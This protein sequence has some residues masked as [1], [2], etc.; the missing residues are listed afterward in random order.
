M[1]L[2]LAPVVDLGLLGALDAQGT[3]GHIVAYTGPVDL[4]KSGRGWFTGICCDPNYGGRGIASI[5][6]NQLMREFV[7]EGAKFSTLFTGETNFAQKIYSRA[8][9]RIVA[10]FDGLTKPLKG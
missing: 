3:G 5:L 6:F 8:G 10:R 1:Q 2:V 4:Q 9:F 7:A